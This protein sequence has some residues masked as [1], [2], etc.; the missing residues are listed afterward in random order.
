MGISWRWILAL[1]AI[2]WLDYKAVMEAA[3]HL[4]YLRP[5]Q[6]VSNLSS[7]ENLAGNLKIESSYIQSSSGNVIG[8]WSIPNPESAVTILYLHGQLGTRGQ[9]R[10]R[11]VLA[12]LH[13]ELAASVVT[14][15]PSGYADSTGWPTAENLQRDVASVVAWIRGSGLGSRVIV[16]GHS[17]G[18][19]LA[20]F[21]ASIGV[22]E[23][24]VLE[25]TF[26][27]ISDPVV[28]GIFGLPL[29]LLP[30]DL[31][32]QLVNLTRKFVLGDEYETSKYLEKVTVPV[33]LLHGGT[34]WVVPVSSISVLRAALPS[35]WVS[36][37]L[38]IPEA[39][40]NNLYVD[41]FYSGFPDLVSAAILPWLL[42]LP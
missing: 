6:W 10:R 41:H 38:V 24:L 15:D 31:R 36:S 19:P 26:A 8:V 28:W 35:S 3:V 13:Q 11:K 2:A 27:S 9:G 1:A 17:L 34:D 7:P 14:Y 40:H 23:G 39:G 30:E 5:P 25:A 12:Y 37:E 16:W 20:A 29:W 21:A 22:V 42:Q 32:F 18:G 4:H 33:F